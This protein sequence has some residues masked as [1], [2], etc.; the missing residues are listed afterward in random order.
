MKITILGSGTS[1]G[2]PVIGCKCRVCTSE[3]PRN[4]RTRASILVQQEGVNVLV[5]TST[6]FREQVLRHG[7]DRIDAVLYTHAHADHIHGIDDLRCFN[8]LQENEIPVYAD[9]ES[10]KKLQKYFDYIFC[11][12]GRTG[13]IPRLKPQL[14]QEELD[15]FGLKVLSF[16]LLHGDSVTSGFRFGNAAYLTDV[17]K[18]PEA[19]YARLKNLDV[20]ILDALRYKPHPTHLTLSE[21]L[22]EVEKIRPKKTFFTHITHDVDYESTRRELPEN[23]ELAYDGLTIYL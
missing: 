14:L 23:V 17:K 16:P 5:D 9:E 4:R 21:A 7:I 19:S 13:F 3:D 18:I 11:D 15:L 20:L 10:L 6:D 12:C 22:K 2:V 1:T 8:V